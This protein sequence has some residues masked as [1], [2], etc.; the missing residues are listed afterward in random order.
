M[1]IINKKGELFLLESNEKIK[2]ILTY[3]PI[4]W[5]IMSFLFVIGAKN[6][7]HLI[8]AIFLL[9]MGFLVVLLTTIGLIIRLKNTVKRIEFNNNEI[10]IETFKV[11]IFR[12]TYMKFQKSDLKFIKYHFLNFGKESMPGWKIEVLKDKRLN[13]IKAFFNDDIESIISNLKC[14]PDEVQINFPN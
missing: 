12:K 14:S 8:F 4:V 10:F 11:S 2:Q 6:K 5:I 9:F 13:L 7:G 3:F 1:A